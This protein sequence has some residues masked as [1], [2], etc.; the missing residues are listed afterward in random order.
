MST[1][2]YSDTIRNRTRELLACSAFPEPI[3]PPR[4]PHKT[5]LYSNS[6]RKFQI[7][8]IL[9]FCQPCSWGFLTS[10]MWRRVV[11]LSQPEFVKERNAF[12]F[13]AI[14]GSRALFLRNTGKRLS[15]D[16]ASDEWN[17]DRASSRKL[18][19]GLSLMLPAT[20]QWTKLNA[21]DNQ[22]MD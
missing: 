7:M 18:D 9:R 4:T 20:E 15:R 2:N 17:T 12:I 5:L 13:I 11:W 22:T 6:V 8:Q 3:A 14:L 10:S 1:E 19:N 16:A 21:P